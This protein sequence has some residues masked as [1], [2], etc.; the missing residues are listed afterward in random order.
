[1]LGINSKWTLTPLYG[2]IIIYPQSQFVEKDVAIRA[3]AKNVLGDVRSIVRTTERLN[4]T[5][6]R[7]SAGRC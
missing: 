3:K 2:Q 4:M 1:V 5:G 6:F 7:V